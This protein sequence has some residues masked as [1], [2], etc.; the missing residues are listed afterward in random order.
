MKR[1][2]DIGRP[3]ETTVLGI[4]VVI[5]P[6]GEASPGEGSGDREPREPTPPTPPASVSLNA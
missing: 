1:L 3:V 2:L 4:P 6:A 5:M